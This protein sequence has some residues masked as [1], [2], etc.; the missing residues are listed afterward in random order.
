MSNSPH[1]SSTHD[2][3]NDDFENSSKHEEDDEDND[4]DTYYPNNIQHHSS[5]Y[6]PHNNDYNNVVPLH[7]QM[8][9][10]PVL[11]HVA[12]AD[13]VLNSPSMA[14]I[15]IHNDADNDNGQFRHHNRRLSPTDLVCRIK[16]V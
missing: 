4:N 13:T 3:M 14:S 6:Y 12:L 15:V 9:V 16:G 1:G 7:R 10:T 11:D 5:H 8:T 2:G